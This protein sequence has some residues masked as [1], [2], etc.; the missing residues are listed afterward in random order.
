MASLPQVSCCELFCSYDLGY[1]LYENRRYT[2]IKQNQLKIKSCANCAH[3]TPKCD[4]LRG[5]REKGTRNDRAWS[6]QRFPLA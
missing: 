1:F 3:Q 4:D 2:N 5:L 6:G